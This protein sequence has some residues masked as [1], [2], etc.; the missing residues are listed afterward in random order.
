VSLFHLMLYLGF[1]FWE[2]ISFREIYLVA[3]DIATGNGNDFSVIEVF[4]FPEL[5]QVA[6]YRSNKL[7][8]PELYTKIK[9]IVNKLSTPI[10]NKRPEVLWTFERNGVGEAIAAL[11]NTDELQPE[12]AELI[13]DIP[14]KFGMVTSSKTKVLSCLQLKSLVEKQKNGLHIKSDINIF[15]LKNFAASGGSYAAKQ[16][17]TDDSVM[18]LVLIARLIKYCAGFDAQAHKIMYSYNESDYDS[19]LDNSDE[20]IPILL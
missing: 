19:D 15:E 14:G 16:G 6:E 10:G 3:A 9:W 11:Y 4:S 8:I 13:N 18:A 12:Y 1:R 2:P 20:P 5:N 17:A 7:N